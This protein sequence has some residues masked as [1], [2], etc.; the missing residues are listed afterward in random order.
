M[1]GWTSALDFLDYVF[2][3]CILVF[4]RLFLLLTM[5]QLN[6]CLQFTIQSEDLDY[7]I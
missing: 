4:D 2:G 3:F 1:D 7:L 5:Y 6:A